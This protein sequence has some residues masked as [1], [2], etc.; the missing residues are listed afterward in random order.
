[1]KLEKP[2]LALMDVHLPQING[3]DLV[4]H[5][6]KDPE[7]RDMRIIMTSGLDVHEE[8]LIAGANDFILKPYMPD[9]LIRLIRENLA[10]IG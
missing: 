9:H 2:D 3:Y 10:L 6:R 5:I 8:C 7:L 4:R 1:M